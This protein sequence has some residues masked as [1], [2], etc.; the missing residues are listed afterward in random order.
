MPPRVVASLRDELAW[1]SDNFS[2][3]SAEHKP[4]PSCVSVES[5]FTARQ[6]DTISTAFSGIDATGVATNIN[7]AECVHRLSFGGSAEP[8]CCVQLPA[9]RHT[10]AIEFN[11]HCVHE[12]DLMPGGPEC[13][14]GDVMGFC[15]P[16]LRRHCSLLSEFDLDTLKPMFLAPGAVRATAPC[17]KHGCLCP[18]VHSDGHVQGS[19]CTDFS[20]RGN[21]LETAG[22]TICYWL[23]WT[24]LMLLVRPVW[25]LCENVE[26]FPVQIV[27]D[28]FQH[29]YDV[30]SVVLCG[31]NFGKPVRRRRRYT[32][33]V[34]RSRA[35]LSRP[36]SS[37]TDF[38]RPRSPDHTWHNYKCAVRGEQLA[39]LRWAYGRKT[40]T[41]VTKLDTVSEF[42]REHWHNALLPAEQ[43]RLRN[44]L[45]GHDCSKSVISVGQD[46][47]VSPTY[48]GAQ[49]LHCI[50]RSC[51]IMWAEPWGRWLTVREMLLAQGFPTSQF[52]LACVQHKEESDVLTPVTSFNCSRLSKML[53]PRDRPDVAH[54]CGNSMQVE[55]VGACVFFATLYVHKNAEP[56]RHLH[57]SRHVLQQH[58][59]QTS[60]QKRK[61]S[62]LLERAVLQDSED[63]QDDVLS[64]CPSTKKSRSSFGSSSKLFMWF[65]DSLQDS[66]SN[67]STAWQLNF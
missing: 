61:H 38:H 55:V 34:L 66:S 5:L 11:Q 6:T 27:H 59:I 24:A 52:A 25:M 21:R 4:S 15:S 18:Y 23:A 16:A 53:P 62:A 41:A 28:M 43:E 1:A 33:L 35:T 12:L 26:Q 65:S 8:S 57:L 14:F 19:P 50:T 56:E 44:Y 54:Q 47:L 64:T 3:A 22:P 10:A 51:H 9:H 37:V 42:T 2:V 13:V 32:L 49:V 31:T 20:A 7:R 60:P 36:L 58:T 67:S 46:P 30:S 45:S 29:L 48:S 39:E 40:N 17:L 63:T